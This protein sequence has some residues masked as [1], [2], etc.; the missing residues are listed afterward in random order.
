MDTLLP[1]DT[2]NGSF[3]K[4]RSERW[5]LCS[6]AF[7]Q[8]QLTAEHCCACFPS[9]LLHPHA[10]PSS[11]PCV[12]TLHHVLGISL[13]SPP[14]KNTDSDL[15]NSKHFSATL[16]SSE[17]LLT[18]RASVLNTENTKKLRS[19]RCKVELVFFFFP[20]KSLSKKCGSSFRRVQSLAFP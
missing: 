19:C 15:K 17:G 8:R 2:Q 5:L 11:I 14:W 18:P 13:L 4:G 12:V 7:G 10:P 16:P 20:L 6:L 1:S 9:A 3:K